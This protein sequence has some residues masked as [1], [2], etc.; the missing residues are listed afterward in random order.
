MTGG[1]TCLIL[2]FGAGPFVLTLSYALQEACTSSKGDVLD[3]PVLLLAYF[4][5]YYYTYVGKRS[6][7]YWLP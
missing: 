7:V 4:S 6:T 5:I 3:L 2:R 1:Q